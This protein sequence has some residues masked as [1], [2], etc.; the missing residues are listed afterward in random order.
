MGWR[1]RTTKNKEPKKKVI[2][3]L[4]QTAVDLNGPRSP[5]A[6]VHTEGSSGMQETVQEEEFGWEQDRA[7]TELRGNNACLLC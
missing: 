7:D 5:V 1:V 6:T 4:W 3:S 2:Y